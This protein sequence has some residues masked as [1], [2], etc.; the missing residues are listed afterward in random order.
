MERL[1]I[2]GGPHDGQRHPVY[3]GQDVIELAV[4][5]DTPP[6]PVQPAETT[7]IRKWRYVK[8]WIRY[9]DGEVRFLRSH[10]IGDRDAFV[11]LLGGY[12]GNSGAA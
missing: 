10:D 2:V 12:V 11:L 3:D 7:T 5:S 9:H 4:W 8:T 6:E 1:L